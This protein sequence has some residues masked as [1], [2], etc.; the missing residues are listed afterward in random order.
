MKI[1]L[2]SIE[3]CCRRCELCHLCLATDASPAEIATEDCR[4]SEESYAK[5]R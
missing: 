4:E 5:G 2:F 3:G 1:A